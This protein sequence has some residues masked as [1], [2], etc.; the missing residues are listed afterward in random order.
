MFLGFLETTSSL[1][2]AELSKDGEPSF[3]R[4][5]GVATGRQKSAAVERTA[6]DTTGREHFEDSTI[7][8]GTTYRTSARTSKPG[9][10]PGEVNLG[11]GYCNPE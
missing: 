4:S 9:Q 1:R 10:N 11:F 7:V 5:L 6:G 8:E 2:R 3:G